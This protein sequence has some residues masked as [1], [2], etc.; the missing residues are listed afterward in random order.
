M[1]ERNNRFILRPKIDWEHFVFSPY[2]TKLIFTSASGLGLNFWPMGAFA[3]FHLVLTV[4]R[5]S[6]ESIKN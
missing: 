2:I 3:N 1:R 5:H 4:D 6:I